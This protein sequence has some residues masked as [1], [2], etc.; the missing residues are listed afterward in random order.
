MEKLNNLKQRLS[1]IK[2]QKEENENRK[3]LKERALNKTEN[4]IKNL[5]K[6]IKQKI[7]IS[8]Y[9]TQ[10]HQAGYDMNVMNQ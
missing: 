9:N 2:L 10:S 7:K 5:K 6:L 4:Q 3:I 1:K 8:I